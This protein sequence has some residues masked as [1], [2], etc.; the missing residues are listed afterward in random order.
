MVI[1]TPTTYASYAPGMPE[2]ETEDDSESPRV[3]SFVGE[4]AETA[5][6]ARRQ[7]RDDAR[8]AFREMEESGEFDPA[9][10]SIAVY[11]ETGGGVRRTMMAAPQMALLGLSNVFFSLIGIVADLLGSII[12]E[13]FELDFIGRFTEEIGAMVQGLVGVRRDGSIDLNSGFLWP[14]ITIGIPAMGIYTIYLGVIKNSVAKAAGALARFL[15]IALVVWGLAANAGP[16]MGGVNQFSRGFAEVALSPITQLVDDDSDLAPAEAIE[17]VVYDILIRN[18]WLILHYGTTDIESLP[19]GP[20]RVRELR[21][22][23]RSGDDDWVDEVLLE[24]INTYDNWRVLGGLGPTAAMFAQV[25]IYTITSG[26]MAYLMGLLALLM[27]TSEFLLAFFFVLFIVSLCI[28]L[29]PGLQSSARRGM[30][31]FV[32][33]VFFRTGYTLLFVISFYF[34]IMIS[35]LAGDLPFLLVCIIQ[36]VVFQGIYKVQ[37]AVLGLFGIN[38]N[39]NHG[40]SRSMGHHTRRMGQGVHRHGARTGLKVLGAF[41]IG[42]LAGRSRRQR[43]DRRHFNDNDHVHAATHGKQSSY[44]DG[45]FAS[46]RRGNRR[47]TAATSGN[48]PQ[49]TPAGGISRKKSVAGRMGN[50]LGTIADAPS[51]AVDGVKMTGTKIRSAPTNASHAIRQF[52]T[53]LRDSANVGD[54][55]EARRKQ[56]EEYRADVKKK[57]AE[58]ELSSEV[59]QTDWRIQKETPVP[60]SDRELE[61]ARKLIDK[62]PASKRKERQRQR[63]DAGPEQQGFLLDTYKKQEQSRIGA[64]PQP[65]LFQVPSKGSRSARKE[66]RNKDQRRER[67]NK[68]ERGDIQ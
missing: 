59:R 32:N 28:S 21:M 22:A 20:E 44:V 27:V 67:R 26:I 66:Q 6:Q 45:G 42:K 14:I 56:R 10:Y 38:S 51:R 49:K 31:K 9:Q 12:R 33:A 50:A 55:R 8:A 36:I 5:M 58:N 53:N 68:R 43:R 54:R 65:G 48:A 13:A 63:A 18:P 64:A 2:R 25:L 3:P 1:I 23:L 19:D 39:E 30:E 7:S 47:G 40:F 34:V 57:R 24:E 15:V 16:I 11:V 29:L 61:K 35:N 17:E 52:G 4:Q 37:D 41:G 62:D 46:G 60:L